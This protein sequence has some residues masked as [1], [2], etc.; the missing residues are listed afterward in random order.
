MNFSL[1]CIAAQRAHSSAHPH[2]TRRNRDT[3][4]RPKVGAEHPSIPM[5]H[6][7]SS[8]QRYAAVCT[9]KSFAG[10]KFPA[11]SRSLDSRQSPC[12]AWQLGPRVSTAPRHGWLLATPATRRDRPGRAARCL[13]LPAARRPSAWG[14]SWWSQQGSGWSGSAPRPTSW[15]S[16]WGCQPRPS[17][18]CQLRG[19]GRR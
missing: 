2:Q 1:Q 13:P 19:R 14:T 9:S 11:K 6:R 10:A 8:S 17:A 4:K 7:Y 12:K 18:G 16:W 5:P 3:A 15:S